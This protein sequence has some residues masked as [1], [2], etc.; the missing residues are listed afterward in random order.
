MLAFVA[1]LMA[2]LLGFVCQ[3]CLM[4]GGEVE[5]L[6][7]FGAVM[8]FVAIISGSITLVMIPVV[9]RFAV[10]PPP[11]SIVVVAIVVGVLPMIAIVMLQLFR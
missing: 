9:L 4:F 3:L 11:R 10:V 7:V 8:L 1:T 2:E 6:R 5:V